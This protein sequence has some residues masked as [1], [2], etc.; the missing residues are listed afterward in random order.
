MLVKVGTVLHTYHNAQ[1][2][3]DLKRYNLKQNISIV[4]AQQF[5]FESL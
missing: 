4:G 1:Q 3:G 2:N 5:Y